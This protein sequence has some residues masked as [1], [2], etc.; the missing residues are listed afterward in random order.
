M[1]LCTPASCRD[2][3]IQRM[4][5]EHVEEDV[6]GKHPYNLTFDVQVVPDTCQNG[7]DE[8]VLDWADVAFW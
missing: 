8:K 6:N 5:R 2:G 3:D 4:L 1:G 7:E